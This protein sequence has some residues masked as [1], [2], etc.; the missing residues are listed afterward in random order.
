MNILR[1]AESF[2]TR[3]AYPTVTLFDG[4]FL[5]KYRREILTQSSFKSL[6]CFIQIWDRYLWY[7]E[8]MNFSAT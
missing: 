3:D 4:L 5:G 6:I 8:S 7:L 2:K 1:L